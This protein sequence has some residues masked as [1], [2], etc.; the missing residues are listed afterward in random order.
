MNSS[1]NE[2]CLGPQG[3]RIQGARIQGERIHQCD[4][5]FRGEFLVNFGRREPQFWSLNS[6]DSNE[7]YRRVCAQARRGAVKTNDLVGLSLA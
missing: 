1:S 2:D 6:L 3:E 7:V 5:S 4:R